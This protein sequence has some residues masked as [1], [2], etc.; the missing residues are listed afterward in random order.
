MLSQLSKT[1]KMALKSTEEERALLRARSAVQRFPVVEWRQRMEDFHKRSINT[2]RHLAGSNAWRPSDGYATFNPVAH[3]DHDDWD[4]VTIT[5][6]SHPQWDTRSMMDSA[7]LS[8]FSQ[9]GQNSPGLLSPTTPMSPGHWSSSTLTPGDQQQHLLTAPR[10]DEM[11]NRKSYGSEA[12]PD[13]DYFSS[14][15][16][17]GASTLNSPSVNGGY[18]DFLARA[19]KT[20]AKDQ[21]HA[22]DPFLDGSATPKKPF[23]EHSRNSS[24]DSIASIVDEKSNSPLNKAIASVS[25]ANE[26]AGWLSLITFLTSLRTLMVKSRKISSRNCRTFLRRTQRV[27]CPSNGTYRRAKRLSSARSERISSIPRP[28][29]AHPS[30]TRSGDHPPCTTRVLSHPPAFLLLPT[31]LSSFIAAGMDLMTMAPMKS[32]LR[33]S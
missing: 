5:E 9:S 8:T 33:L 18:D 30:A 2:S 17:R 28:A 25:T 27:T 3:I 21:K 12:S 23:G 10:V 13:E 22:P 29:F 16:S 19:N 15:R 6:P 20:I 32:L 1:I 26:M 11:G 14:R 24:R 4:P 7:R 31:A